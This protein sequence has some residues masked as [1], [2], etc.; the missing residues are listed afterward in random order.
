MADTLNPTGKKVLIN[1]ANQSMVLSI[2][3]AGFFVTFAII[4]GRAL[5][6]QRSYQAKV[7][8]EK[9]KAVTQLEENIDAVSDLRQSYAAF[10]GTSDNIIGGNPGALGDRDGDNAKII[11]DALPSKYDFP[12]FVSS[13]EK[14]MSLK[15]F[16]L[17]SIGGQDDS[18]NQTSNRGDAPIEIP[19]QMGT[20]VANNGKIQEFFQTLESSIRP[21]KVS[22]VSIGGTE[23]GGSAVLQVEAV[24]YYQ[25]AKG[26]TIDMKEI[27]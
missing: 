27:K 6:V 22:K 13:I 12:A 9:E 5:W 15:R 24:S 21:I 17:D 19:F 2:A 18:V 4:A 1:K 10:T 14:I 8:T 11:L 20:E 16:P 26:L 3:L 7:I 25:A 23:S